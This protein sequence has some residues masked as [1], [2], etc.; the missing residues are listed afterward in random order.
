MDDF[1]Y[2]SFPSGWYQVA[3]AGEVG[4]GEVKPLHYFGQDLV[5]YRGAS[6]HVH[7]MDAYCPHL[8]A[9][10]GHGG[11]VA[12]DDIICPFHGWR[13]DSSGGNVEIP[14][15]KR[16]NKAQTIRTWPVREYGDLVLLWYDAD[17]KPPQWE[18]PPSPE[19]EET[20]RYSPYPHCT[21]LFPGVRVRPQFVAENAVDPAHQKYVHRAHDISTLELFEGNGPCFHSVQRLAFG[22]GKQSTWLTPDGSV[23]A[24][25]D[26]EVWG[27]GLIMAR[28]KGTDDS[29][30]FQCQTPI[31]GALADLRVTV[32]AKREGGDTGD[33]PTGVAAKR[34]R[35]EFRQ[36]ENDLRIW[37]HMKYVDPAPFPPE[38]TRAYQEFRRWAAQFYPE[39]ER[40]QNRAIISA[41]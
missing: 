21:K 37:E 12:G 36:V 3:W 32:L 34:I 29:L 23:E 6:G 5:M 9:H 25:L 30:H 22:K 14:Y 41:V 13:W 35:H 27:L 19:Y 26:A 20:D 2:A 10:L 33:E 31:E 15:S 8:G 4:S 39:A 1:P 17:G 7:V 18:V 28:F 11:C 40:K 16:L 24:I 38:E